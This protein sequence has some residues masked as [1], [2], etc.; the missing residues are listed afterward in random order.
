MG[1]TRANR[2]KQSTEGQLQGGG[3]TGYGNLFRYGELRL[4]RLKFFVLVRTLNPNQ[5]FF[6]AQSRRTLLASAWT[7]SFILIFAY[8]TVILTAMLVVAASGSDVPVWI[9]LNF[10]YSSLGF[11]IFV[12]ASLVLLV[13]AVLY[14]YAGQAIGWLNLQRY[15]RRSAE[16]I[17]GLIRR[18]MRVER[19][20]NRLVYEG[21][22]SSLFLF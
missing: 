13:F 10:R 16:Y 15:G 2:T 6:R 22:D 4:S 18:L 3:K 1:L 19:V 8:S 9:L 17:K 5:Q 12:L 14:Y 11:I 7:K 21:L 20:I